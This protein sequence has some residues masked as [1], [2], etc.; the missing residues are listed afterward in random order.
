[1]KSR[2]QHGALGIRIAF[3]P[4]KWCS[5]SRQLKTFLPRWRKGTSEAVIVEPSLYKTP[6]EKVRPGDIVRLGP[7]FRALKEV[8]HIGS[9]QATGKGQV[10]ALLLGVPGSGPPSKD[11]VEGKKD[12]RLVVPATLTWAVL[13]TRG[14]DVENGP[15]RQLAVL[16]PLSVLQTVDAKEAVILGKHSSL[17]YLPE[18]PNV[19]GAALVPESFADFRFVVTMHRDAFDKLER[20]IALTRDGL[21]DMYFSWMRHTI[22]PQVRRKSPCPSCKTEVEVFQVVEDLLRPQPD[23]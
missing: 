18:P 9:Q 21:L 16:R 20:P 3:R 4:C 2:V 14:C 12:T 15:Q 5:G 10:S 23:Y 7:S 19:V 8:V 11:V 1:M 6:D 22:G 17:H 13:V